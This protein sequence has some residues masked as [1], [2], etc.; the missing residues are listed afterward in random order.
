M[1][2]TSPQD[3]FLSK[4]NR[5]PGD[6]VTKGEILASLD[7]KEL[8]IERDRFV[9]LRDQAE[10]KLRQAMAEH[11][12]VGF[13]AASADL[14]SA[15]AQLKLVESKIN[16]IDLL[17]PVSGLVVSG[18]WA[19]QIGI[20]L[21]VGK[22]MFEIAADPGLRVAMHVEDLDIVRVLVDQVGI[23]KLAGQP[24]QTYQFNVSQ[25]TSVATVRDGVN[26]FRVEATWLG[27]APSL[28]PGMQGIGKILVGDTVLI[29]KWF[30]PLSNWI[31]LKVWSMW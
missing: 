6:R 15:Q 1:A 2:V 3:G 4:V 26:G 13:Q 8:G 22:E 25:V 18:D 10:S 24:D 14:R 20:P 31:R 21:S 27:D 9:A 30:R 5:R 19:H 28:S 23:L 12:S 29:V 16:R 7:G 11:E 17:A